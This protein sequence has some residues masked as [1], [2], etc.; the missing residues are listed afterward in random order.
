MLPLTP[1]SPPRPGDVLHHPAFGFATVEERDS[2]GSVLRWEHQGS[3]H[4]VH[5]K[6]TALGNAYRRCLADGL[7]AR[8]VRGPDEARMF[9][10]TEPLGAVAL[11]LAELGGTLDEQIGRA[12]V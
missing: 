12:H 4:P 2:T 3:S 8:S 11:L 7:L 5:V 9:F 1:D 6:D 10:E